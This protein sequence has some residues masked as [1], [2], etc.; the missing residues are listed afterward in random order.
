MCTIGIPT[1]ELHEIKQA[2]FPC[3]RGPDRVS[4]Q[5]RDTAQHWELLLPHAPGNKSAYDAGGQALEA[6]PVLQF[7]GSNM[8]K[9]TVARGYTGLHRQGQGL[10]FSNSAR[11]RRHP[12]LPGTLPALLPAGCRHTAE[13]SLTFSLS[14]SVNL[15]SSRVLCCPLR[16]RRREA[17]MEQ[18]CSRETR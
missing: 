5:Q 11:A 9:R 17:R 10:P 1:K 6:L 12:A 2:P 4:P 18:T 7:A 16:F 13:H 8:N 3:C 14:F 15:F